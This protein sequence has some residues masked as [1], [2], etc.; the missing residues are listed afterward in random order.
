[1]SS[2][3][4]TGSGRHSNVGDTGKGARELHKTI[5]DELTRFNS[6]VQSLEHAFPTQRTLDNKLDRQQSEGLRTLLDDART[7]ILRWLETLEKHGKAT[8]GSTWATLRFAGSIDDATIRKGL[9]THTQA[10]TLFLS[11]YTS[12]RIEHIEGHLGD[13]LEEVQNGFRNFRL[14]PAIPGLTSL[15]DFGL[16]DAQWGML[17]EEL[18]D[19]GYVWEDIS[20]HKTWFEERLADLGLVSSVSHKRRM[21]FDSEKPAKRQEVDADND[22][23][24]SSAAATL[25]LQDVPPYATNP[26]QSPRNRS[27][28][29]LPPL[30]RA[31]SRASSVLSEISEYDANGTLIKHKTISTTYS[32][33]ASS[34]YSS[35]VH[36]NSHNRRADS[37]SALASPRQ[38][39]SPNFKTPLEPI[40]QDA[41]MYRPDLEH[42]RLMM[43]AQ[44]RS[45]TAAQTAF[46][47]PSPLPTIQQEM[48]NHASKTSRDLAQMQRFFGQ[49]T[50]LPTIHSPRSLPKGSH[51]NSLSRGRA[52]RHFQPLPQV[53][54]HAC[55][56]DRGLPCT[57]CQG[58]NANQQTIE[59]IHSDPQKYQSMYHSRT[60]HLKGVMRKLLQ[61]KLLRRDPFSYLDHEIARDDY[62]IY[63]MEL[64]SSSTRPLPEPQDNTS[65]KS[66]T[67]FGKR[68][69]SKPTLPTAPLRAETPDNDLKAR[70][71]KLENRILLARE[72]ALDEREQKEQ[73]QVQLKD[74]QL[75][76]TLR[77][78]LYA[79][80][81]DFSKQYV[82]KLLKQIA[83]LKGGHEGPTAGKEELMQGQSEA[84]EGE[85]VM[86]QEA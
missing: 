1:M 76:Y 55:G 6:T 61:S 12:A 52:Q 4:F 25:A 47:Q 34:L 8:T 85:V 39:M 63:D 28:S 29:S 84:P 19:A 24:L 38:P 13:I 41:L 21:S 49:P 48:P 80:T 22:S 33:D 35:R 15:D 54:Q 74:L 9:S 17:E 3:L 72:E 65:I 18:L 10:L 69:D 36:R 2:H 66:K 50:P 31:P 7:D 11:S 81:K 82:A 44:E 30:R 77:D 16:A 75:Q 43:A 37:D 5:S 57:L 32:D 62:A 73:L 67:F 27:T 14:E 59:E 53:P 60:Q 70:V 40:M 58:Y 64:E 26:M 78:K 79:D 45:Q 42:K 86:K 83:S 68:R 71:L 20:S 51:R 23:L 46:G 56:I